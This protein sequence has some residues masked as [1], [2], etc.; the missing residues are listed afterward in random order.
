MSKNTLRSIM[1]SLM[2][3]APVAG[4]VVA[5]IVVGAGNKWR[6]TRSNQAR[7]QQQEQRVKDVLPPTISS[8]KGIE[9]TN[10]Y[11][12]EKGQAEITIINK[13]DKGIRAIAITNGSLMFSDDNGPH[14]SGLPDLIPPHGTYTIE[15]VASNLSINAP[16]RISAVIFDDGSEAGDTKPRRSINDLRQKRA[17]EAA[18]KK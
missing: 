2:I 10:A 7:Q 18:A 8:L 11:I 13:T 9:V 1:R 14:D 6:E 16:L 17:R 4:V 12:D 3:I 15:Q 5:V